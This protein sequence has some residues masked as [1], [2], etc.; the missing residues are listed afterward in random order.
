[1]IFVTIEKRRRI[2]AG[3]PGG[4]INESGGH[5]SPVAEFEGALAEAASGDYRD[6]VGGA[7]VDFDE[8][9]EA[10]AVFFVAARVFYAEL[11]QAEHGHADAEDL[12]GAKVAVG[13]FGFAD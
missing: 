11:G 9:Y 3:D 2:W 8:S 1:M 6:G 10:L 12:A 13:E 5:F 7:A 4:E